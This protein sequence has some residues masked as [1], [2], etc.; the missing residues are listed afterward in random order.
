M[1]A[2]MGFTIEMYFHWNGISF[3]SF[4]VS[5]ESAFFFF[6]SGVNLFYHEANYDYTNMCETQNRS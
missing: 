4:Y 6:F 2:F 5:L 3:F 1:P